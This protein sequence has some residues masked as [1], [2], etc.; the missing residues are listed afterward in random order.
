MPAQNAQ[1]LESKILT[2]PP[3][4][5]HLMLIEGA[6]RFGRQAAESLRAGD[7]SAASAPLMRAIDIVGEMLAGVRQQKTEVNSRLGELYWFI[8]QRLSEAKINS[9]SGKLAEA[10]KLLEY[11][12]DTWQLACD[13]AAQSPAKKSGTGSLIDVPTRV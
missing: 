8:F 4:R 6:L 10:M 12:R 7:R 2:A 5:L 1:Y 9:D 3:Q 11:E 13:K